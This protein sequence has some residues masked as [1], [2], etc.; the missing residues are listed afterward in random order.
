MQRWSRR[1]C[2]GGAMR[3]RAGAYACAA[4]VAFLLLSAPSLVFAG[5]LIAVGSTYGETQPG[6]AEEDRPLIL[7]RSD[8]K[9]DWHRVDAAGVVAGSL[10]GLSTDPSGRAWVFGA[11]ASSAL[12][13]FSSDGGASWNDA[14]P[15]LASVASDQIPVALVFR[16]DLVGWIA[17]RG[18]L[19]GGPQVF[20]TDDGA[21]SWT[22][23]G[24]TGPKHVF[25]TYALRVP[26][27]DEE[28]VELAVSDPHGVSVRTI[29]KDAAAK[30]E[31]IAQASQIRAWTFAFSGDTWW[32]F[33]REDGCSIR[34]ES[35]LEEVGGQAQVDFPTIRR[36]DA[37]RVAV[38]RLIDSPTWTDIRAGHFFDARTGV[39]GGETVVNGR[40]PVLLHTTDGGVSWERGVL[41]E[42]VTGGRIAAVVLTNAQSGWAAFN[43]D[44][45]PGTKLL[46]T[47]DG[48]QHWTETSGG[49][50]I[51]RLRA[52][53][54]SGK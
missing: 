20:R 39:A 37:K 50:A 49:L 42:S 14:S 36:V 1:G 40:V 41:P 32:M 13:L 54:A 3:R 33:G 31:P 8:S 38:D 35:C 29:S 25:G 15:A 30:V 11:S 26:S 17:T 5:T 43:Y 28:V 9:D 23:V 7:V 51:G 44:G 48:G 10:M 6:D 45:R 16:T 21:R 52:L 19:T 34:N 22:A 2:F 46:Q 53:I 18:R 27:G 24:D 47:T 4:I 12:L